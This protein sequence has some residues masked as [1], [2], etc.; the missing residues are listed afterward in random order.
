M[1]RHPGQTGMRPHIAIPLQIALGIMAIILTG[2]IVYI[3]S[4]YFQ[5]EWAPNSRFFSAT[6]FM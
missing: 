5:K 1:S 4:M 6:G 3:F 2:L